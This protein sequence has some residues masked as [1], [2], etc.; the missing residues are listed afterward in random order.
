MKTEP[1]SR[2]SLAG[3]C[4]GR[5]RLRVTKS[6]SDRFRPH[7]R[8]SAGNVTLRFGDVYKQGG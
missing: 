7:C 3:A 4:R 6:F 5:L 1:L 8:T 2:D